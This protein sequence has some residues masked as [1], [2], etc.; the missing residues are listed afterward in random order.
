MAFSGIFEQHLQGLRQGFESI[1]ADRL[2]LF[3]N[4][5]SL[6]QNVIE[7]DTQQIPLEENMKENLGKN[8]PLNAKKILY[9]NLKIRKEIEKKA[10][11]FFVGFTK[12]TA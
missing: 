10:L 7:Q 6:E 5:L 2:N 3:G 11:F 9:E 12:E 1:M 8:L 4:S